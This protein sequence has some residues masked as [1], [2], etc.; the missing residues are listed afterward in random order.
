MIAPG[1]ACATQPQL[2]SETASH[3]RHDGALEAVSAPSGVDASQPP[4]T[5]R[6]RAEAAIEAHVEFLRPKGYLGPMYAC[7]GPACHS[8]VWPCETVL[9]AYDVRALLTRLEGR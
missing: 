4:A 3:T 1:S 7:D 2:D 9:L 5:P 6:Q 8:K